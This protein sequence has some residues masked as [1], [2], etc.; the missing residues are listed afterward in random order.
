MVKFHS[1]FDA[2]ERFI[3]QFFSSFHY[4]IDNGSIR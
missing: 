4:Q 3:P 2:F 1:Y